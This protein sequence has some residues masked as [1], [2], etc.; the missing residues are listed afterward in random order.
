MGNGEEIKEHPE[1][2]QE[3]QHGGENRVFFLFSV[4]NVQ[5]KIRGKE[6]SHIS[7]PRKGSTE[8]MGGNSGRRE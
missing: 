7:A 3:T 1:S 2:T 6:K 8:S 4:T 5:L